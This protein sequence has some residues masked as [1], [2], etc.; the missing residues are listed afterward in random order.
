MSADLVK[1]I[2]L[3]LEDFATVREQM[4]PLMLLPAD[5][6]VGAI[7]TAA[8][9]AMLHSFYSE[10]E[11]ILKIIAK[12]W[13]GRMSASDA[14]HKDL[15]NQMAQPTAKRPAILSA[16]LVEVLSEFLAF[17]HLFRGASIALMRW[18]KLSPL[19]A[20][21]SATYEQTTTAFREFVVFVE[22]R[23]E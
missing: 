1:K 15:L 2:R 3:N 6:P 8:A 13:D 4:S 18:A 21:V 12:E 9:C 10:I 16:A 7:E 5:A 19:L 22:T 14:W 20:K 11:K 17:R 23:P